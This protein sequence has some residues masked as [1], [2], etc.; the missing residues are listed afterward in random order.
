MC[1]VCYNAIDKNSKESLKLDCSY[2]LIYYKYT[3]IQG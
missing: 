3:T 1:I 2:I